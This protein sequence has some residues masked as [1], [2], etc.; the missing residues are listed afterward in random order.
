M[1]REGS[2]AMKNFV[3]TKRTLTHN[4]VF[5]IFTAFVVSI[6][7]LVPALIR[8]KTSAVLREKIM[9]GVI[10]INNCRFCERRNTNCAIA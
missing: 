1:V 2:E 8:P 3:H 5:R 7:V 4:N 9:L 6:P 10:S